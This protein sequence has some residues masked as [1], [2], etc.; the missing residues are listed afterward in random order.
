[1]TIHNRVEAEAQT[2]RISPNARSK[3]P[4]TK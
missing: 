3:F 1:M 2:G 4:M